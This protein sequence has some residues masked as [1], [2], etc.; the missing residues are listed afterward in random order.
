[1][2]TFNTNT[3]LASLSMDTWSCAKL[4]SFHSDAESHCVWTNSSTARITNSDLIPSSKIVLKAG[5]LRASCTG[6]SSECQL[7][8]VSPTQYITVQA[9]TNAIA[10][11]IVLSGALKIS[12]CD[13]ISI[14]ASGSYG[15]GGRPWRQIYWEVL[16]TRL[17]DDVDAQIAFY[18]NSFVTISSP[19]VIS[20]DLLVT[21]TTYHVTLLLEN[22]LGQVS[23]SY[24]EF[25]VLGNVFSPQVT[26]V[27]TRSQNILRSKVVVVGGDGFLS[28]CSPPSSKLVF[29]WDM[30]QNDEIVRINSTSLSSRKFMLPVYSLA[31]GRTYTITLTVSTTL[32]SV[33]MASS[34]IDATVFVL[35]GPVV[36]FIKGSVLILSIYLGQIVS[37]CVQF[38]WELSLQSRHS[39][40]QS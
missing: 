1:M 10:P 38:R 3:D 14:D 5:L 23:T 11:T 7:N 22:F 21:D 18:L 12:S 9:P 6:S 33:V 19:I 16:D 28:P 4:F 30:K 29:K 17:N 25:E 36:A 40:S 31:V 20:N 2:V 27:G 8:F 26:I 13:D 39:D 24:L 37:F 34:S 32:N 35:S 15:S